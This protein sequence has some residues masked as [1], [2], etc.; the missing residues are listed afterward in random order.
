MNTAYNPQLLALAF[1]HIDKTLKPKLIARAV[2]NAAAFQRTI[3]SPHMKHALDETPAL[4]TQIVRAMCTALRLSSRLI[5]Y[6]I[7][8]SHIFFVLK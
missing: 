7:T 5:L 6:H 2:E 1:K 3:D 8:F 4:Y